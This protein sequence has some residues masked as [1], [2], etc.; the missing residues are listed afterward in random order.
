MSVVPSTDMATCDP[1][2]VGLSNERLARMEEVMERRVGQGELPGLLTLIA[3]R[4]RVAH[5]A[6]Y[7]Y[8]DVEA[9][10]PLGT[11]GILGIASLTKPITTVALLMVCEQA[12]ILLNEPIARYLPAFQY[13][14]VQ[15][16]DA[17][18]AEQLVPAERDITIFDCLTHTGGFGPDASDSGP[19]VQEVPISET[20]RRI[21]EQ[22]LQRQ[23]GTHWEYG[24]GHT[25][26]GHLVEL[27]ADQPLETYVKRYIFDPLGMG[28][29]GYRLS[30]AQAA[31]LVN[32]YR[33]EDTPAGPQL[34][35]I[36]SKGARADASRRRIGI[37]GSGGLFTTASDYARFAQFLLN[38]G[39]LEDTR[40]LGRKTVEFMTTNHIGQLPVRQLGAGYSYGLGVFVR[41]ELAGQPLLGS[42]G[43]FGWAGATGCYCVID[44][45]EELVV[46]AFSS[47]N[48][49][50]A[51]W[52][53]GWNWLHQCEQFAYQ[54]ILN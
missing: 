22:P 45:V 6:A 34:I 15:V 24:P 14:C 29:T 10:T 44:P 26:A 1:E 2:A 11:D 18:G 7:G 32:Q 49:Y 5:L 23:P 42:L 3:R 39:Q 21:A 13:P 54:A 53:R 4:G 35:K 52:R 36:G 20:V 28:D 8:D 30:D 41:R 9:R 27:I 37:T 16:K 43:A 12:G 19:S 40:L 38:R 50:W 17:H 25:I 51:N 46:L 48:G 33:R 47:T 31:R